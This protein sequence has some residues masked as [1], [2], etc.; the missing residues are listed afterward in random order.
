M[1]RND[2]TDFLAAFTFGTVLGIG[3]IL[4]LRPETSARE[5][6]VRQLKPYGKQ[7]RR[8][9]RDVRG[10][11]RDGAEA[12]GELSGEFVSAGRELLGEFRSE[13]AEI[14]NDARGELKDLARDRGRDVRRAARKLGM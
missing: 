4:L 12:T 3:A 8:S 2:S 5:R 1:T 13:V 7:I 11:L 6:A 10:G 9:Y 14:L